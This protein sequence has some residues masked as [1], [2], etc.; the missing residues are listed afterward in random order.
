MILRWILAFFAALGG[1]FVGAIAGDLV[2]K[3]V[4]LWFLPGAGF[5]AALA[6]VVVT[7]LAAPNHKFVSASISFIAGA[8]V[9]WLLLE[10]S[11]FP[12]NY[13][14]KAYQ[15][16]HLP[17]I[18]T[19]AGGVVG[20]LIAAALRCWFRPNIAFNSDAPAAHRLI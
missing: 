4:G 2:A 12:E 7:Y 5:S 8:I 14:E 11:C 19:Y 3:M 17:I 18:T 6:V 20:L 10:P 13:G 9:A 15:P 16:T 1:F